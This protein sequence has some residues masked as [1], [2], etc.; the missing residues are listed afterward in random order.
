M[1]GLTNSLVNQTVQHFTD[2]LVVID[3]LWLTTIRSSPGGPVKDIA[4]LTM[5]IMNE[6]RTR[7]VANLSNGI[8]FT[9]PETS[10]GLKMITEGHSD[11][12][13]SVMIML[14]VENYSP[15]PEG[16]HSN[17]AICAFKHYDILYCFN[18]WGGSYITGNK[19]VPDNLVWERIRQIYKCK[20]AIVYSGMNYQ[21]AD[22]KG[23]CVGFSANFG[24]NMYIYILQS[25]IIKQLR[26]RNYAKNLNLNIKL[27]RTFSEIP[28]EIT[29]DHKINNT[30][31]VYFSNDFNLF[32]QY[33]FATVV[34]AFGNQVL[35]GNP[36]NNAK[37]MF[38][39]LTERAN[40]VAH[41]PVFNS[42]VIMRNA[43]RNNNNNNN[44]TKNKTARNG[45]S[46]S[47]LNRNNKNNN[48]NTKN[49][50]NK[51]KSANNATKN[52]TA[53]NVH[54]N[55]IMNFVP[56]NNSNTKLN[57]KKN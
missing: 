30:T 51:N 26:V 22:T 17:H 24:I 2:A 5:S 52:K 32:V 28:N 9:H 6:S 41:T 33:L 43:N 53:K 38:K 31:R 56:L 7:V 34:S 23:A 16:L 27:L 57:N 1:P 21:T 49:G 46:T 36:K 42:N 3:Q 35:T 15:V 37:I 40:E 12:P 47:G 19:M 18:P 13:D 45:A 25:E 54:G 20:K 11:A 48:K 39:N 29:G 10:M 50:A 44:K 55:T 4:G 8:D 14:M